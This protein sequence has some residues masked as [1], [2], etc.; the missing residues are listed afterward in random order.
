MVRAFLILFALASSASAQ[1]TNFDTGRTF[2]N[3]MSSFLDTVIMG[4]MRAKAMAAYLAEGQDA[5]TVATVVVPSTFAPRPERLLLGNLVDA[6]TDDAALRLELGEALE[7]GMQ[8]YES[9]ALDLGR[10]HDV[11]LAFTYFVVVH[12]M[13]A[14]FDEPPDEGADALLAAFD[15]LLSTDEAFLASGDLERQS[16]Y[17]TLVGLAVF[18]TIGIEAGI[19]S[20][21][22]EL[23]QAFQ[24]LA[25]GFLE[26]L[27]G[28]PID[29][30]SFDAS[31]LVIR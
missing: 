18:T 3:P 1:W 22:P 6:I 5:A 11:G 28:A 27:L 4:N 31:G 2:N 13:L 21:D 29:Q 19:E 20:E 25:A 16:L 9:F 10:P 26:S 14:T 7:L 30:I 17:E 23:V 12:Y 15:A 24:E 8:A